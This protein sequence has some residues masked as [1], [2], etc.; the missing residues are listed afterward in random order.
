MSQ[1]LCSE[2]RLTSD[3]FGEKKVGDQ[4]HTRSNVL[5]LMTNQEKQ[6]VSRHHQ[7]FILRGIIGGLKG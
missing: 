6:S 4:V 3:M 2:Y 5:M 1:T 7:L